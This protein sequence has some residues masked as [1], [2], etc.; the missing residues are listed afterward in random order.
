LL[1]RYWIY[2]AVAAVVVIAAIVLIAAGG[3]DHSVQKGAVAEVKGKPITQQDFDHWLGVVAAVQRPPKAKEKPALPKKGTAEY[4]QL[5]QQVMQFLVSALWIDG[6]AADRDITATDQEVK[7]Q[8]KSTKDQSFPTEKAYK[9][10]LR[11]SGQSEQDIL[12]RVRLDVLSNKIRSQVTRDTTNVD[13]GAIEDYYKQNEAQF[14]QPERRD[15]RMVLADKEDKAKQAVQR[16]NA[17]ESF[18]KVAKALSKD[19][20]T[21][22][23]GGRLLGITKGQQETD[24]DK[25][26]FQVPKGKLTGPIKTPQGF[27]VFEVTKITPATKQSLEQSKEGI[28]QLLI[29][30][31]QQQEL[32]KFTTGFRSKWRE[33][34]DCVKS[35]AI[36]DC[37]NGEEPPPA[38]LGSGPAALSGAGTPPALG[39]AQSQP[40]VG[41]VGPG[42]AGVAP[43]S[44][45]GAAPVGA[46]ATAPPALTGGGTPPA[47][48]APATGLPAGAPGGAVPPQQG[49]APQ[50]GAQPQGSAPP[51][52]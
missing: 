36:P 23:Q 31:K 13:D 21:K 9:K 49:G 3:D 16:I 44:T 2:A 8:F 7:K 22:N 15:L 40:G 41:G 51:G 34:T 29:S 20:A 28:R 26:L 18:S 4:D 48:S 50:G 17:G 10:F 33:R 19:P 25:A 37:S 39:G 47:L 30:Q 35:L 24:F 38:G 27:Y 32:D 1:R 5:A 14:S 43:G 12:Y 42:A 6:E 11:Q 52:G 46:A 45:P